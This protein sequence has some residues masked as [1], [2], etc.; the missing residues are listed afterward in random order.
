M[1]QDTALPIET[2]T[3]PITIKAQPSLARAIDDETK[4]MA[5]AGYELKLAFPVD[6]VLYLVFQGPLQT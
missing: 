4:R 6:G 5:P 1:P 3:K 2:V